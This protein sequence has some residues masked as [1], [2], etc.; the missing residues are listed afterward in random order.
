MEALMPQELVFETLGNGRD[1][2]VSFQIWSEK[3][4]K[5]AMLKGQ[6]VYFNLLDCKEAV[7][8][9]LVVCC[10]CRAGQT[11]WFP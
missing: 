6:G 9:F 11:T 7:N 3:L 10:L 1:F 4:A 5:N 8:I 2:L